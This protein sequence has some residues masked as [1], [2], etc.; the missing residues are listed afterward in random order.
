M[1]IAGAVS[2]RRLRDKGGQSIGRVS[3]VWLDGMALRCRLVRLYAD[4][5]ALLV[6]SWIR[7]DES[8]PRGYGKNGMCFAR[9]FGRKERSGQDCVRLQGSLEAQLGRG[10]LC[11][12][13]SLDYFL[14]KTYA[15]V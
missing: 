9:V 3:V 4:S 15:P 6:S 12:I 10:K 13:D 14:S 11:S 5:L 2:Q 1:V 7:E 8:K